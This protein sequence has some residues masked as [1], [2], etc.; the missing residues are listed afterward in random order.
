MSRSI[1]LSDLRDQVREYCDC[2]RDL[3][4]SNSFLN[5]CINRAIPEFV[6]LVISS[7]GTEYYVENSLLTTDSTESL[8]LPTDFYKLTGLDI[9]TS[10]GKYQNLFRFNFHQ[11]NQNNT[12]EIFFPWGIN[13]EYRIIGDEIFFAPTPETGRTLRI[14]YVPTS[15]ILEDDGDTFDFINGWEEY[16]IFFCSVRVKLK[17]EESIK[18]YQ[19]L[20]KDKRDVILLASENRDSANEEVVQ[21]VYREG[22]YVRGNYG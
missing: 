17:K 10:A 21:D 4:I 22:I 11:R 5:S 2:V 6:D 8:D 13:I 19:D 18:V 20:L 16:V 15:I 7:F 9:L 12:Q 1:S 3:H 14:W